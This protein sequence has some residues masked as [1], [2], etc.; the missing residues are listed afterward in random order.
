MIQLLRRL[1]VQCH[2]QLDDHLRK[3]S[4][5]INEGVVAGQKIAKF[6]VITLTGIGM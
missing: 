6:S 1:K 4:I 2:L 3:S 5:L